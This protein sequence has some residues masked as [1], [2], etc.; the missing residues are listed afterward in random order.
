MEALRRR[1]WWVLVLFA[2]GIV[3]FGAQDVV[4]GPSGDPAIAAGLKGR[5]HEELAAE[6]DAAYRMYDHTARTQGLSLIVAG[7]LLL[8]VLL[9]PYRRGELWAWR[10]MWLMPA[11]SFSIAATY[12]A[13]GLVRG[14]AP[15][16]PLVSGS[17]IGVL[18]A[19]ALLV[20]RAR[21]AGRGLTAR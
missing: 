2:A 7:T 21:F 15:P 16:P 8:A 14:A 5:T 4:M 17:I 19:L 11:W 3:V 10:S 18:S 1:S 12:P 6:S 20:D 13:F 9:V